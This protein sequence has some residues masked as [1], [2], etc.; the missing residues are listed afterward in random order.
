MTQDVTTG[1][2]ISAE[3]PAGSGTLRTRLIVTNVIIAVVAV[4]ALGTYVFY[5]AQQSSTSLAD[6]LETNVR[7]EAE[8]G[9]AASADQQVADLNGF[10]AT[11]RRDIADAGSS[12]AGLLSRESSLGG[13]QYWD[14]AVAL[15][16]L[17]SGSWDNTATG[18]PASLFMPAATVLT[19]SLVQELNTLKHLDFVV[20][21]KL[22]ANP[23][24]VALYFGGP[25]GETLYY[26]DIDLANVVPADFDVTQRPW[27]VKASATED[28]D[29]AP[30]WSDPYLDAALHGL[31]VT[32]ST[33][34]YDS[35]GTF[36]GVIAMDIQLGRITDLVSSIHA[37][38]T[39]YAFLI[40]RDRRLIAMPPAAYADLGLSADDLPLGAN[41]DASA[42]SAAPGPDFGNLLQSMSSG[43]SGLETISIEGTNRFAIY[44][45]VPEVGYSMVILVPSSELLAGAAAAQEQLAASST[46]TTQISLVLVA[47]ILALAVVATVVLSNGLVAPLARLT[48]T[49]REVSAGNLDARAPVQSGDEIGILGQTL[50]AMTGSLRGLVQSLEDR[51]K[52]RTSAL[53]AASQEA[54]RR[55]AQFEAITRVTTAISSIRNIDELLPLVARV[56]S[57]QFG[58]YHVGIFVN[59]ERNQFTYLVAANSEGGQRMLK[60]RHSLKIGE[61]GIVGYVAAHG[62]SR[63]AH[64]VGE[65]AVFFNNPDLPLTR[66]EAALPLRTAE[67]SIGVLDMQSRDEAAFTPEDLGVLG[68]LADQV[69]LAFENARLFESTRRSLTEAESLY[70]QYLRDAWRGMQQDPR[71]TGF[72][73]TPQG[74]FPLR[75]GDR[76]ALADQPS[77]D[78]DQAPTTKIPIRLRGETIGDLVIRGGEDSAWSP[79]QLELAQAVADRVALAV[80]NARLFEETGR[81][82]ERERLV[83]EITSKIRRSTDPRQMMQTAVDEL[84]R[85]LGASEIQVIPQ[86]ATG[87]A[88][89]STQAPGPNGEV[90]MEAPEQDDGAGP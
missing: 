39:G 57:E 16:R 40:D 82:A 55:A 61:Q 44:R 75:E 90:A 2:A 36:R 8:N 46:N 88:Q 38:Q 4:A 52:E 87:S 79:Q 85:V 66:S 1:P 86:A 80:E 27:Y 26:P 37:G 60:R 84:R 33:P 71:V 3:T 65:D 6:Q 7:T 43:Q 24:A 89:E 69:S 83:T 72:R 28:P 21:Q 64:R 11:A 14:A 70:H 12:A 59:D 34:V 32:T 23:D 48:E 47:I 81:R 50:N 5:R 74:S 10:F 51:V 30:V 49:A 68:I 63:V 54:S 19:D 25:S 29:R 53:E 45:P 56:I 76:T 17:P 13:G 78:D 62:D 77:R 73:F 15:N 58:Y 41:L 35:A 20:P 9:L 31:V 18:D 67:T 42:V 22:A